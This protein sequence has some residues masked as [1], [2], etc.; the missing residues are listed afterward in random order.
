MSP[1]SMPMGR[2]LEAY[3]SL[4]D[5]WTKRLFGD[6]PDRGN[7]GHLNPE[8]YS[9]QQFGL[10]TWLLTPKCVW[11]PARPMEEGWLTGTTVKGGSYN[12]VR[13]EG[14]KGKGCVVPSCIW[15]RS[16]LRASGPTYYRRRASRWGTMTEIGVNAMSRNCQDG[17]S[18]CREA[19]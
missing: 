16:W 11:V 12:S 4:P 14:A 13:K 17:H 5:N 9:S 1:G 3:S 7:Y 6:L 18:R 2:N 10:T 15:V 8:M 19:R